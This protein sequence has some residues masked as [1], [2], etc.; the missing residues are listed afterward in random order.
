MTHQEVYTATF[1][2]SA[3]GATTIDVASS[4][5]ND[6]AGN[7]NSA[8]DQYNWTYD[9]TGPLITITATDGSNAV[10][11]GSFTNDA[12]LTLTFTANESVTG[13]AVGDVGVIGGSLSSFS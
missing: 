12:T 13:F 9:T 10:T 3:E 4:T 11:S 5:F 8:A 7:D 6:G 1:T 2:P